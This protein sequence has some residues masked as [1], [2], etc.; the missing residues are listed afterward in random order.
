MLE[1]DGVAIISDFNTNHDTLA[2]AN[3]GDTSDL[4]FSKMGN[5]YTLVEN[6]ES[7]LAFLSDVIAS[8][9]FNVV[10]I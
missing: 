8:D 6:G 1:E 4:T 3:I 10:S 5:N 7:T 9:N 2:I